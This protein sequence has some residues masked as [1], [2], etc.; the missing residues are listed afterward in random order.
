MPNLDVSDIIVDPDFAQNPGALFYT[1]NVQSVSGGG[2]ASNSPT[3]T[4]LAGT[5][6]MDAGD[7]LRRDPEAAFV[8]G[9]ILIHTPT[10]LIDGQAGKDADI[11]TWNGRRYTVKTVGD[12][13]SFGAG[14]IW[15]ICEPL[16][17]SGS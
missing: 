3:T 17:L 9:S 6:T 13:S 14:F 1:R 10:H 15:A 2:I 11:V 8:T 4:R 12:Y 5:V 7:I 16:S